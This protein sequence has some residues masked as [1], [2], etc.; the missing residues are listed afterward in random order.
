MSFHESYSNLLIQL[1]PSL[2]K[3]EWI[4][5]TTR[6]KNPLSES[7]A[8]SINPIIEEFLKHEI[9][10]YQRKKQYQYNPTQYIQSE[11]SFKFKGL[12]FYNRN[13]F[14]K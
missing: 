13:T 14:S 6:K 4:R 7:E 12:L 10:R 3:A 11:N 2:I 5:L 1:P 9:D 8:S